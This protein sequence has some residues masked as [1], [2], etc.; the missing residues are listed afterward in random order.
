[1]LIDE[2]AIYGKE[3]GPN[4]GKEGNE[5]TFT[6]QKW[7]LGALTEN[8][9]RSINFTVDIENTDPQAVTPKYTSLYNRCEQREL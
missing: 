2:T 1:M 4:G 3:V 5:L 9:I 8:A 7:R 6:I